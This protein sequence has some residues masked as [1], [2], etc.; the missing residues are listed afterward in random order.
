QAAGAQ[1]TSDIL[2]LDGDTWRAVGGLV[3]WAGRTDDGATLELVAL[4]GGRA[5]VQVGD[6]LTPR[7]SRALPSTTRGGGGQAWVAPGGGRRRLGERGAGPGRPPSPAATSC[8][9]RRSRMIQSSP[10]WTRA[11]CTATA[12][13]CASV[14]PLR[15]RPSSHRARPAYYWG[16]ARRAARCVTP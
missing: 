6:D 12:A 10:S 4:D 3:G 15:A 14:A 2:S 7:S 9:A 16:G 11:R 5:L 8:G 1:P 13:S